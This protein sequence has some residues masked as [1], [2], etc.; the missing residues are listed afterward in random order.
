[1]A[2]RILIYEDNTFLRESI[3][4]MLRLEPRFEIIGAFDQVLEV[5]AQVASLQPDCILLDIDLPGMSGIEALQKIRKQG[6]RTPTVMLTVFEDNT[7]VLTAI[8]AGASGYV[9]KKHLATKLYQAIDEA[10]EGGAPLSPSVAKMVIASLQQENKSYQLTTREKEILAA[11]AQ[12][13]SY[14]MI[15]ALLTISTETVRTHI[16]NIYEK[17]Q[18]HSQTEAV[19]KAIKENLV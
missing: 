4:G 10:I 3:T 6:V 8:K 2:Q 15:G 13:N 19:A 5:E 18:V 16:K 9:L 14:K 11:L 1:M 17:L 12:G 7:H